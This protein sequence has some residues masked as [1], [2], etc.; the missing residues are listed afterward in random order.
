MSDA[1]FEA[2]EI[3]IIG[4]NPTPEEIAAVTAVVA[5]ALE[6]AADA[7]A[8]TP[9][10]AWSWSQRGLRAPIRVHPGAWRGFIG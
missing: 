2:P 7:V 3:R 4:G 1:P 9:R 10:S 8:P 5:A 6:E